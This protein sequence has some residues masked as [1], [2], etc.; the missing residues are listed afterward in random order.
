MP[1]MGESFQ[2]VAVDFIGPIYP[3]SE[4]KNRY[5]LTVVDYATQYLE[6]IS[7]YKIKTERV[8]EAL[9]YVSAELDFQSRY[10]AIAARR[11]VSIKELYTTPYNSRCNAHCKRVNDVL[12]NMLKKICQVQP[13]DWDQYL[14]AVPFAYREIP[15]ASTDFP[16]VELLIGKTVRGPIKVL[17]KLWTHSKTPEVQNT[18]QYVF[19]FKN[20]LEESCRLAREKLQSAQGEFKHHWNKKTKHRIFDVGWKDFV[21]CFQQTTTSCFVNEK[22]YWK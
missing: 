15:Q 13:K 12:K 9:L 19:D 14:L 6:A 11:L 8:A 21:C 3:M 1:S 22:V 7:L 18:H 5:I 20:K 4:N 2:R 17:N 10:W 16:P